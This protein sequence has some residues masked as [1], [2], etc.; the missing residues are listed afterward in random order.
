[1]PEPFFMNS[2]LGKQILSLVRDGDFAH[3]GEEEAIALAQVPKNPSQSILDAGCGRGGTAAYMQE[4]GWG[5]VTG[6]DIEPKSI[7][8]ASAT[9]PGS[10]F[11]CSDIGDAGELPGS[12]DV[13]TLFNVFYALPDHSAALRALGN[14]AKPDGRLVIFDYVDP[15]HYQD[16]PLMDSDIR[17]IPNPPRLRD[18]SQTLASGGWRLTS[19]T[20]LKDEYVRW[21]A[22]LVARIEA[23][24]EGIENLSSPDIYNHVLGLYSGLLAA[25]RDGRLS[26]AVI[27]AERQVSG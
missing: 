4:N 14:R 10:K 11:I 23:K 9:F 20:D 6:I 26:G 25:V 18:L 27:H 22:Y 13:I 21:Y 8:Y 3:A 1:M 7:A 12:F 16:A 19:L 15:G 24:R 5:R 17:F 2:Y